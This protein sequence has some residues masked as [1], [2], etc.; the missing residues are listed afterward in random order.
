VEHLT[1]FGHRRIAFISGPSTLKSAR[2][3]HSAFMEALRRSELI[4]PSPLV[5]EGDHRVHGGQKAMQ[6]LLET[7]NRPTAVLSSNDLTAIGALH[8][9]ARW[10]LRVPKDISIVGFDDIELCQYT[11]PALTTIRLSRE[12]IGRKAF[13]AL[14]ECAEGRSQNGQDIP[15]GTTLVVRESTGIAISRPADR[16]RKKR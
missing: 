15:I 8:A 4:F 1:A 6:Q 3:R 12:E 13:E 5:V 10:G 14:F 2:F 16:H 9:I 7:A 11:Q